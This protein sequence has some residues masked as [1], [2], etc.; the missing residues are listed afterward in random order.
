MR[1]MENCSYDAG[2]LLDLMRFDAEGLLMEAKHLFGDKIPTCESQSHRAIRALE[3]IE[4]RLSQIMA[5]TQPGDGVME[6][7]SPLYRLRERLEK[8]LA[9]HETVAILERRCRDPH[10]LDCF[11]IELPKKETE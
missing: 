9:V 6:K 7:V 1:K 8:F 3:Q 4:I 10:G 5:Q 11:G 2:E